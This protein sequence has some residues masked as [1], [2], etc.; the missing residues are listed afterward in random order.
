MRYEFW[1]S[2]A[3]DDASYGRLVHA[4]LDG[5]DDNKLTRAKVKH[6]GWI[7][8]GISYRT[9]RILGGRWLPGLARFTLG[10]RTQGTGEA[11]LLRLESELRLQHESKPR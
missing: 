8:A 6:K 11:R 5:G 4:T 2:S 1:D 7:G 3:L 10:L 9:A